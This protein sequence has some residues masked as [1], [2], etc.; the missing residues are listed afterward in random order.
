M[1]DSKLLRKV[2]KGIGSF[3]CSSISFVRS[4]LPAEKPDLD[5]GNILIIELFEMGAAVMLVP[6]IKAIQKARPGVK[7]HCLTTTSCFPVWK[8]LNIIPPERMHVIDAKS[9]GGFIFSTLGM[10]LQ[11]RKMNFDLILDFEL[12]MRVPAIISGLLKGKSRGGFYKYDFE[13][14]G[15]GHFYQHICAYNQN[16][17]ISKNYLSLANTALRNEKE[18]PNY[19]GAFTFSDIRIDPVIPKPSQ[20]LLAQLFGAGNEKRPYFVVCADVGPTLSMRNYPKDK[21]VNVID[22]LF[23]IYPNHNVV[24]IG[25]EKELGTSI[26]IASKLK[27]KNRYIE[28]CGKT[29]FSQLLDV[30]AGADLVITNDNGPGHFATLT[31][32]KALALFSTDSPFVYGPLGDAVIAY[33][34]YQ[35]SP[36]ISAFNHKTSRCDNNKCLQAIDENMVLSLIHSLMNGEAKY[37]TINNG[38]PYVY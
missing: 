6:T 8:A 29:S 15:R 18:S 34:H 38:I 23:E 11:L 25:T 36:C 7:I 21:F 9:A 1:Q 20:A 5:L 3:L 13:G 26:Y 17:H 30:I 14:L 27:A 28:M 19:K 31:G 22:K 16:T 24:S 12:F 33:S 4:F 35:C 10:L 37:R 2:D 32:T